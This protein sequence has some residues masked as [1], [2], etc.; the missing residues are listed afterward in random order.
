[1][2]NAI[3]VRGCESQQR[4]RQGKNQDSQTSCLDYSSIGNF[5]TSVQLM[6]NPE[7]IKQYASQ[8]EPCHIL[9]WCQLILLDVSYYEAEWL[10]NELVCL[11]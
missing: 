9:L 4:T 5:G 2:Y 6:E 3:L 10:Q 7:Q 1:M 8:S 11:L